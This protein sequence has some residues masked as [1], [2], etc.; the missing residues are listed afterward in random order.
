VHY[1]TAGSVSRQRIAASFGRVGRISVR[2]HGARRP[3]K[4]FPGPGA[5]PGPRQCHGR[6]PVREVGI[7]SGR[8]R[9]AGE[10]GFARLHAHRA[11]GEV[12]RFYQRV[13]KRERR[14]SGR[15]A[16]AAARRRGARVNLL[17]A[18]DPSPRRTVRLEDLSFD[19]GP[20]LEDVSAAFGSLAEA[21][22]TER[23]DGIRIVRRATANGG[24]GTLLLS[25]QGAEPET[26]TTR[27]PKPLS[28]AGKFAKEKGS[29]ATWHGSLK[30]WLPGSGTVPLTGRGFSASLCRIPI[31]RFTPANHCL[32]RSG[33]ALPA[34]FKVGTG[35]TA[36]MSGSQSQL[37]ADARLSW[38]R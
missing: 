17:V 21:T 13:C 29:P 4:P 1:T 26:A 36:H 20:G 34:P 32:R 6:P 38:D 24:E 28:G 30:A 23:N 16:R 14:R 27:P 33:A 7:F 10:R 18:T 15:Q 2:F 37:F 8:I 5:R 11:R 12:R 22:I 3:F 25:K 31:A 19:F 9:F 35:I